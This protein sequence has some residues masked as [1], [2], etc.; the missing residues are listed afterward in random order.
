MTG[1]TWSSSNHR[2]KLLH[3]IR[4]GDEEALVRITDQ[5]FFV[6]S[7]NCNASSQG[8]ARLKIWR[9]T[10]KFRSREIL[11]DWSRRKLPL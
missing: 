11:E 9:A 7:T 6:F 2:E 3:S 10:L 8:I 5:G 1:I 4:S